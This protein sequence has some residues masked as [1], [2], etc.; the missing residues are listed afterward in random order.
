MV[1]DCM[2]PP[3]TA[4]SVRVCVVISSNVAARIGAGRSDV[5]VTSPTVTRRSLSTNGRLRHRMPPMTLDAAAFNPMPIARLN[6]AIADH[7]G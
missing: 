3:A 6:T 1:S 4:A 7:A 5:L 2:A